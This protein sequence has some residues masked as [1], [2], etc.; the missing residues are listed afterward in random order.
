MKNLAPIALMLFL[1]LAFVFAITA[2]ERIKNP[3][4][5]QS[6][7]FQWKINT[8][9][10]HSSWSNESFSVMRDG[11]ELLVLYGTYF[12]LADALD[13]VPVL[14]DGVDRDDVT[15]VPFFNRVSIR[16]E[17][18]LML[19]SDRT[20]FDVGLRD[21]EEMQALAFTVY[22][23]TFDEPRGRALI[24]ELDQPLSF[25]VMPN[26]SY[27]YSAGLFTT[28]G[29]AEAYAEELRSKGNADASIKKYLNGSK[30]AVRDEVEL[31]QY[32]AMLQVERHF[33]L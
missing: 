31:E 27:A 33:R 7:V 5:P 17:D 13:H 9:E 4:L 15:L 2:Q 12:N 26:Y 8:P 18:A 19:L 22:F 6:L 24:S 32:L 30:L 1:L 25:E 3:E 23:A 16:P 14:P 11:E 10:V 28:K 20:A 21:E 29:E